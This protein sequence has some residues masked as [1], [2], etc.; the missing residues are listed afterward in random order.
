MYIDT[1]DVKPIVHF[2]NCKYTSNHDRVNNH[3]PSG[4]IDKIVTFLIALL[5]KD[6]N[7]KSTVNP[8]LGSKVEEVW[9]IFQKTNPDFVIHLCAN[10]YKGLEISE[11]GRFE[12]EVH[13]HSHFDIQYHL[14]PDLVQRLTKRGKRSVN[15]K[16]K[17]I[18]KNNF[19]K[20]DGDIRALIVNVDARDL[21]RVV[22]D[23]EEIRNKADIADY[24]E[25]KNYS[26]LEDAFED[27]VRVYLRQRSRV[28]RNIKKTLLSD[29]NHRFFYFNNGITITCAKF[30]YPKT[31]R[32]PL[33][34]LENLQIV[35]GSQTIHAL[36]DAFLEKS[37]QLEHV[38]LLCRIYETRNTELSSNIAEYTNSQNPVNSRDIRSI[39]YVQQKLEA[40]FLAKNLYYER[41]KNQFLGKPRQHRLDAEK[42]GQVLF[43]FY[44]KMPAEAKNK[45]KLIFAEKYE[46]IFNDEI[47]ADKV[48]TAYKLFEKIEVEK[49]ARKSEILAP[50]FEEFEGES[51]ILYASY[52]VLYILGELAQLHGI[53][54]S[55]ENVTQIWSLYPAA[56]D[57]IRQLSEQE[58]QDL[59]G[60]YSHSVFFVSTK[61]KQ[62]FE[63]KILPGLRLSRRENA[64]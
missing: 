50:S 40:E 56:L 1:S 49:N 15:A 20:S 7:L 39:D 59:K 34:E 43:A 18:D 13:R 53:D 58:R 63:E 38:D 25:L 4:E 23:S 33:I 24:E 27:N 6:N 22:L 47:N 17:G 45:K 55:P 12:R 52:Y 2:F 29:R 42:V 41:K 31:Q 3:F 51:F 28:N 61:L 48:L 32:G 62:G 8:V 44:N 36:Y 60:L 10:F 57:H 35:N 26:I 11:K 19:E 21:I 30:E 16:L 14:M 5:N 64:K 9:D 37:E 54:L 46:E